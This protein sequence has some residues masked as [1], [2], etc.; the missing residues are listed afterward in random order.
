MR[1]GW[2]FST[3]P[4]ELFFYKIF[5]GF[6][7]HVCSEPLESDFIM[8]FY[9]KADDSVLLDLLAVHTNRLTQMMI[10]GETYK[11]EYNAS[12][13]I[14]ELLQDEIIT[15][16]G[17]YVSEAAYRTFNQSSAAVHAG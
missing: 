5:N 11:G 10:Y 2:F 17:F 13:R 1:T 14:V 4:F 8:D 7:H 3:I 9:H 16:R 12:K 6:L 15:R